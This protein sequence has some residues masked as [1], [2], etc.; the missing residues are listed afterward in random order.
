[1]NT[2]QLKALFRIKTRCPSRVDDGNFGTIQS[3]ESGKVVWLFWVEVVFFLLKH[4]DD[5]AIQLFY[6]AKYV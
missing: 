1:M 6:S 3:S 5:V 2:V 4:A